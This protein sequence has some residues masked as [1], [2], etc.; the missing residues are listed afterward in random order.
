[1]D[2]EAFQQTPTY[3]RLCADYGLNPADPP[4]GQ[5]MALGEARAFLFNYDQLKRSLDP[6]TAE[7]VAAG[8]EL[9]LRLAQHAAPLLAAHA[10]LADLGGPLDLVDRHGPL[11]LAQTEDGQV[12]QLR[13]EP[14]DEKEVTAAWAAGLEAQVNA[15]PS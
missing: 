11:V 2:D 3:A 1:M 6:R 14:A 8:V 9:A 5:H 15:R 10:D 7:D 13:P 12:W 4:D